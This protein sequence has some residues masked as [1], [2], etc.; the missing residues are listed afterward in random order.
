MAVNLIRKNNSEAVTAAMDAAMYYMMIG[1]G[2]FDGVYSSCDTIEA[3]NGLFT[4]RPGIMSIGGRLVEIPE[5]GPVI[6]DI[7]GYSNVQRDL[8]IKLDVTIDADDSKS[9]ASIYVSIDNT[10]SERHALTAKTTYTTI[11]FTLKKSGSTHNATR[12]IALLEPGVAKYASSLLV[13]GKIGN[14]LVTNL[15]NVSGGDVTGIKNTKQAVQ[16]DYA[17]GLSYVDDGTGENKNAVTENLYMPKRGV[18]LCVGAV[19]LNNASTFGSKASNFDVDIS[20]DGSAIDIPFESRASLDSINRYALAQAIFGDGTTQKE[21]IIPGGV[22]QNGENIVIEDSS[23]DM[24]KCEIMINYTDKK[25]RVRF[26]AAR[27]ALQVMSLRV[28]GIGVA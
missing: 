20:E 14:T 27:N 3:S 5:N 21:F 23:W 26:G 10:Q 17:D 7:S 2:I 11:L 4:I 18:Y 13:N 25:V 15:F 22:L 19:L 24:K 6:L 1:E 9:A 8:Y 16:A 12:N 28:V